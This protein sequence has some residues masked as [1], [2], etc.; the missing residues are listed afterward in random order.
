MSIWLFIAIFVLITY[1]A[2]AF[3]F[4]SIYLIGL[5]AD[6]FVKLDDL[7]EAALAEDDDDLD[8]RYES[9]RQVINPIGDNPFKN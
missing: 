9:N 2:A 4:V 1:S 3:L 6:K 8:H 7:I 5:L